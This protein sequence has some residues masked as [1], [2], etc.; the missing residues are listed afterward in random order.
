MRELL[1]PCLTAGMLGD[2]W[3]GAFEGTTGASEAPF[4]RI[5]AVS[6][7]TQLVVATSEALLET[8][9]RVVPELVAQRFRTWFESGRLLG[10]GSSTLKALRDLAAG[11][12]WALSGARGEFAAGAGAAMRAAP[13]AFFLDPSSDSDRQLLR[14]VARITHHH[15]EA[16]A[17]ALAVVVALREVARAGRV[18][19]D[20]LPTVAAHLPDT[21]VRDRILLLA[22]DAP[23]TLPSTGHVVD[24][25]PTALLLSVRHQGSVT[26][27]IRSAIHLGG[28]T[29]TIAAIA[30][31]VVATSGAP[32][33]LDLVERIPD[34]QE[35]RE[36]FTALS[37]V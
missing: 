37:Q 34:S 31:Q 12:H 24:A 25:V 1:V 6:D 9:G 4:P 27:A 17:G 14:D 18:P 22:Q 35:A 26:E 21:A 28:D 36:V 30:A 10:L 33:P 8:D 7:D 20:L 16:Y 11:A 5:P 23:D 2:A 3:G 29:D 15:D 19:A 32:V 13:L